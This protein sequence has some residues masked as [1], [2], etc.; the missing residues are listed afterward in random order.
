VFKDDRLTD[1]VI[2]KLTDPEL[3]KKS[4]QFPFRFFSA[5]KAFSGEQ[6]V[7]TAL[8]DAL[9]LSVSNMPMLGRTLI[10]VDESGSMNSPVSPKSTVTMRDIG[11]IFAAAIYKQSTRSHLIPFTSVVYPVGASREEFAELKRR[12]DRVWNSYYTSHGDFCAHAIKYVQK[13]NQRDSAMTVAEHLGAITGGTDLSAPLDWAM[14]AGRQFDTG[15]FITDSESWHDHLYRKHG[16]LD[17]I[18][19]FRGKNP[20]AQFFFIQLAP[21]REVQVPSGEPGVHF[22]YGW[23]DTVLK[24]IGQAAAG[25]SQLEAVWKVDLDKVPG[26][27]PLE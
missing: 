7:K 10:A 14:A 25:S 3:V 17:S 1:K 4:R 8:V 19:R 9:E 5:Y 6:D 27:A 12:H 21:Y 18:R 2:A 13:I 24:F 20:R 11:N 15:I 22:L 23:S 26:R 16:V